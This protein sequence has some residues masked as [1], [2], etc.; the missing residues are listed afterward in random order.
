MKKLILSAVILINSQLSFASGA[1]QEV[2]LAVTD[3]G[4]VR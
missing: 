3:K 2:P 4:G 1:K